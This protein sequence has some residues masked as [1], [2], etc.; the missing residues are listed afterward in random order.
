MVSPDSLGT[1]CPLSG[2]NPT[3][4]PVQIS[5]TSSKAQK[6]YEL[7]V[8]KSPNNVLKMWN[9][10]ALARFWFVQGNAALGR[11]IYQDALQL[12]VPDT[13]SLRHTVADT[14]LLWSR[15]ED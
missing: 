13:D 11:K 5:E 12:E 2:R 8:D 9:L 7:A 4:R 10:R 6:F 3:Y 15:V 14:Y 1:A